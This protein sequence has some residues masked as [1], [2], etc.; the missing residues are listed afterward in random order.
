MMSSVRHHPKHK[1]L[2]LSPP[3]MP[4]V[5]PSKIRKAYDE[6]YFLA[7]A[8]QL[9]AFGM[10]WDDVWLTETEAQY[11]AGRTEV[12]GNGGHSG[13]TTRASH[14]QPAEAAAPPPTPAALL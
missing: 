2:T 12:G 11:A 4:P 13:D 3:G 10:T 6:P 7:S 5:L 14:Q 1:P 9:A 8:L